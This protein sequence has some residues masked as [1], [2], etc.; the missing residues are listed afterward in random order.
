MNN[1]KGDYYTFTPS[2][3]PLHLLPTKKENKVFTQGAEY[4]QSNRQR[5]R[6]LTYE[7][8]LIDPQ[9]LKQS[10]C[11]PLTKYDKINRI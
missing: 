11:F 2:L 7:Q 8:Q 6:W 3:E 10:K 5:S 4:L 1:N 9:L